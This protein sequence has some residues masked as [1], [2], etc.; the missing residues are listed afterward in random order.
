[1]INELITAL[2]ATKYAWQR[3]GSGAA[4]D[5]KQAFIVFTQV[6][7]SFEALVTTYYPESEQRLEEGLTVADAMNLIQLTGLDAV[8]FEATLPVAP[9][10][11]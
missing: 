7:D 2:K 11:A 3:T 1:M 9:I 6:G 4:V 10:A 5:W 8:D